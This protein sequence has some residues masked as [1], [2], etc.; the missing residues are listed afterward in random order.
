MRVALVTGA[1][2]GIGKQTALMLARE[3]CKIG[4]LGR[5]ESELDKVAALIAAEG[6][7]AIS[8]RA[9]VSDD[10]QMR[11]AM[12][13]LVERFGALHVLVAN[14]GVN[15]VWAPIEDLQPD[16]WDATIAINLRGTYLT[17][18][19]AVP[20]MKASGGG[21]IVIVS[22]INGTRTFTS[23]GATAY[24]A[25]KG[26]QFAMAQQLSLELARYDIRINVV[27]P[28]AIDTQID[29]NTDIRDKH[30]TA[31]PVEFPAG[32]IPISDGK[33]GRGEDVAAAIVFLASD[34]ARHITGTPIWVDG[35][36]GLLR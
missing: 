32:E 9:D 11:D 19:H 18:H 12:A 7:E 3:G 22:S 23:P 34:A 15:G 36:Q 30:E 2:S 35:G 25:T 4:L 16:E 8:L 28:G 10:G 13:R 17:I 6:G 26:A 20:H 14:A 21:A 5:T 31:I 27:C 1:G 29:D 33:P 24:S